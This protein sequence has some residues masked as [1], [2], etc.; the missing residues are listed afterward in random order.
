MFA[1]CRDMVL[2]EIIHLLQVIQQNYSQL[3][4]HSFPFGPVSFI[5]CVCLLQTM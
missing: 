5:S 3:L 1:C 4:L 2:T